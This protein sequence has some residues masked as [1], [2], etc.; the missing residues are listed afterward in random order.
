MTVTWVQPD[1]FSALT[2]V[3]KGTPQW[4]KDTLRRVVAALP[5]GAMVAASVL[6][7]RHGVPQPPDPDHQWGPGLRALGVAGLIKKAGWRES[8]TQSRRGSA[9]GVWVRTELK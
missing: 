6:R 5:A 8:P 3:E 4:W 1:I 7:S 2:A 9:E